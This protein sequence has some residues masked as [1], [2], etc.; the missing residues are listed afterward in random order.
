MVY[1]LCFLFLIH[2]FSV[3]S[4]SWFQPKLRI[5]W[6]G[7]FVADHENDSAFSVDALPDLP[8]SE[9][10]FTSCPIETEKIQFTFSVSY[11][12]F[13]ISLFPHLLG[14]NQSSGFIGA[15][16]SLLIMK[17]MAPSPSMLLP[18]LPSSEPAFTSCPT[19][20]EMVDN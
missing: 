5:H 2:Y 6:R 10:A 3:S 20:T 19:E 18:D 16:F 1:F 15:A 17:M 8:S 9:P 14:F 13:L 12:M 7:F 4:S 11:F